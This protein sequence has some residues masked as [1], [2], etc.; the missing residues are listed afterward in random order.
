MGL[1]KV[2]CCEDGWLCYIL[3]KYYSFWLLFSYCLPIVYTSVFFFS[4]N[5][6]VMVDFVPRPSLSLVM[7]PLHSM[8][9]ETYKI[10][11]KDVS[12]QRQCL[13][14]TK[15]FWGN[16]WNHQSKWRKPQ[17]ANTNPLISMRLL[18]FQGC[19]SLISQQMSSLVSLSQYG[20]LLISYLCWAPWEPENET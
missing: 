9:D 12:G 8:L 19:L 17:G 14:K 15:D 13:C 11:E 16:N 18:Y 2:I 7:P 5:Y 20:I 1:Y 10:E 6:S 3:P 4:W